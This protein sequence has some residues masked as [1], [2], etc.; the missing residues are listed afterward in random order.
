MLAA[1]DVAPLDQLFAQSIDRE[2]HLLQVFFALSG[3]YDD[4]AGLVACLFNGGIGCFV[5]S[6]DR[7]SGA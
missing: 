5:L 3:G 2:R 6:Q 7:H 4:N 1:G